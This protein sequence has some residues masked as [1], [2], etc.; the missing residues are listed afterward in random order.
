MSKLA[1]T[2]AA[3]FI[4]STLVRRLIDDGHT[5]DCIDDLS[6]GRRENIP[7]GADHWWIDITASN[8]VDDLIGSFA[9]CSCVFHMAA[10]TSLPECQ[11]DPG[12]AYAVN[13]AGTA[14]VLEAARRAGVKRVVF[15]SS[16]AVYENDTEYPN[17]E[18]TR[19]CPTLVYPNTKKHAEDLCLS[20]NRAY[21]MDNIMLRYFNVYGPGQNSTRLS[22][23]FTSYVVRELLNGRRPVLHS[24]GTQA[25][26]YVYVDDVVAANIAAW[27]AGHI[28]TPV[29]NVCS[30]RAYSVNELHSIIAVEMGSLITPKFDTTS[31]FWS[32]YPTIQGLDPA[33]IAAEVNK[34]TLGDPTLIR[35]ALDW[36]PKVDIVEGIK[37]LVEASGALP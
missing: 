18:A 23:P 21:G 20:F 7:T 25:R 29:M 5:V 35:L 11:S 9:D 17:R 3:G 6:S 12:R 16:G 37:R 14:N 36:R 28:S 26:D 1:V 32:R 13:V 8:A 19:V 24:D 4:G 2:G 31:Q 27:T 15:S 34:R 33:I 10:M 22:P 30:G